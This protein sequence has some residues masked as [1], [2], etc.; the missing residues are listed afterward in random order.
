MILRD[1][2]ARTIRNARTLTA[3]TNRIAMSD[4]ARPPIR[5]SRHSGFVENR[6]VRMRVRLATSASD[7]TIS[8]EVR[9]K[10][11]LPTKAAVSAAAKGPA[12]H[13]ATTRQTTT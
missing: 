3:L 9:A 11:E 2:D 8:A 4:A 12:A 1:T 7:M 6:K 5:S 10:G 13:Q